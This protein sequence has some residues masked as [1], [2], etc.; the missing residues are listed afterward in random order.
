M[1]KVRDLTSEDIIWPDSGLVF[2]QVSPDD[3]D[4]SLPSVILGPVQICFAWHRW[5]T[6][7][8]RQTQRSFACVV[9]ERSSVRVS[10]RSP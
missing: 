3:D 9:P 4:D 5:F 1:V 6:Q 7:F 2:E 8:K 10:I